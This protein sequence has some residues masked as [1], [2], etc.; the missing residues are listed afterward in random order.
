MIET[1]IKAGDKNGYL[2]IVTELNK[3]N[4]R[5]VYYQLYSGSIYNYGDDLS[6]KYKNIYIRQLKW[7]L[8]E[9]VLI[10]INDFKDRKFF[11]VDVYKLTIDEDAKPFKVHDLFPIYFIKGRDM[12]DIKTPRKYVKYVDAK[13]RFKNVDN[14][15]HTKINLE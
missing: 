6:V 5:E 9:T 15:K 13:D 1:K 8:D 7:I 4:R 14:L 10:P 3:L 12:F 2:K 11:H